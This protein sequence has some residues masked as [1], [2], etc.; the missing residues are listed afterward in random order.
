MAVLQLQNS[1]AC[2][3]VSDKDASYLRHWAWSLNGKYV[4]RGIRH[5]E[6]YQ[7][8]LLHRVIARRMGLSLRG[9]VEVDHKDQNPCNNLRFNIR[10]VTRSENQH[11]AGVRRDS[12]TRIRGVHKRP[13]GDT[14][15]VRIQVNKK[16]HYIGDFYSLKTAMKARQQAER[17]FGYAS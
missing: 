14:Y 5:G 9:K 17:E 12:T 15:V 7:K 8:I 16:R 11:N 4:S 6:H 1:G 10:V 3:L 13:N 2:I